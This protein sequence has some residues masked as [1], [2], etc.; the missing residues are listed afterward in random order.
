MSVAPLQK[1]K[2]LLRS[3]RNTQPVR[4]AHGDLL[5]DNIQTLLT[6][7]TASGV[8]TLTVDNITGFAINQI[9]LIG[10]VGQQNSEI[11]KTHASSAPS[12]ST[13]TLAANTVYPH[14]SSTPIY[15]INYDQIEMSIAA[16]LTGSKTGLTGSPISIMADR[17]DTFIYDDSANPP[18]GYYF[19]RFKNTIT[20]L[21][22]PYSDAMPVTG[23]SALMARTLIDGA[24]GD[25]NK[26]ISNT[27]SEEFAFQSLNDCQYEVFKDQKRWSWMQSFDTVIGSISTGNMKV[28]LPSDIDD[29]NTNKSI[30]NIRI[31]IDEDLIW[32]DKEKWDEILQG[33]AH[34][35]LAVAII[36]GATTITLA[37]S[38]DFPDSGVVVIGANSYTYT[39]NNRTT[40]VLTITASTTTNSIGDDALFGASSGTPRY[41][42]YFGGYA[43]FYPVA[44]SNHNGRSVKADYY[45]SLTQI[46]NDTDIL[47]VP[48][49]A[50]IKH[51]LNWKFLK[52]I[53]NGVEGTGAKSEYDKFD[54]RRTKLIAKESMNRTFKLRGR[55]FNG[56]I[57]KNDP[58][59][60][61]LG[62]FPYA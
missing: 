23:Y 37:S 31:G 32:V 1:P 51:Y 30:Y 16:T 49:P 13:I 61:R 52:K 3:S 41:V 2:I 38:D 59:T 58:A 22:S 8:G 62:G 55:K 18:I 27:L 43:Y 17:Q 11:I 47:V 57:N 5:V 46:V 42:T 56:F 12:G 9:L 14:S 39:A 28:A 36:V 33:A 48:D 20:S 35:T 54:Q 21:F 40:N 26:G 29:V 44:D 6:S 45:K 25:I 34:T 4:V 53:N 7:D 50:L 24:L 15:V 60:V 19:A 10:D